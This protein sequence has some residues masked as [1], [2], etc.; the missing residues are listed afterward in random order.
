MK[1]STSSALV[2]LLFTQVLH[3]LS[4]LAQA[5]PGSS[6]PSS[7]SGSGAG[8]T[9]VNL[10]LSSK[11]HNLTATNLGSTGQVAIKVGNQTVQVNAATMLTPAERLAVYQVMSTGQ[12]S[13][14]LGS[15]GNAIGG[16]FNIGA[17]F[18]QYVS[19]L[20]I[21]RGVTA[22]QNAA[23]NSNLSLTGNLTNSGSLLGVS[24]SQDYSSLLISAQNIF[25]RQGALIST[26]L[27]SGGI[28]GLTGAIPSLNLTL[29]A[30]QNIV[31]YG[32]ITSSGN[33]NLSAGNSIINAL[34]TGTSGT[35]PLMQA[36]GN[37]NFN[38]SQIV[39]AGVMSSLN[40]NVNF[41]T[42]GLQ[43]LSINNKNGT[44]Q[45]LL[46]SIN[47]RDALFSGKYDTTLLGGNLL[48]KELN[49]FSGDGIANVRVNDLTGTV[50]V[51]AGCAYVT[52]A[53]DNLS[54]GALNLSG[55]PLFANAAGDLTLTNAMQLVTNGADLALLA[56]GNITASDPV[57]IDTSSSTGSGGD[58]T[59]VAGANFKI[60][61]INNSTKITGASSTGGSINFVTLPGVSLIDSSAKGASGD[62]GNI[63]L[64]AFAG[65]TKGSGTITLPSSTPINANSVGGKAGDVSIIAGGKNAVVLDNTNP[66]TAKASTVQVSISGGVT[67]VGAF[68]SVDFIGPI[69]NIGATG[70]GN[71]SIIGA[72]PKVS[73]GGVTITDG[74]IMSGSF[75]AGTPTASNGRL[76]LGPITS[77][78]NLSVSSGNT[79]VFSG[80]VDVGGNATVSTVANNGNISIEKNF[81][82]GGNISL[83]ANGSGSITTQ[84]FF[85]ANPQV[86]SGAYGTAITP[87]G[88]FA[89]VPNNGSNTV[90]VINTA[91]NKVIANIDLS[92]TGLLAPRGAATSANG[93]FIYV[94]GNSSTAGQGEV[95]VIDTSN[96]TVSTTYTFQNSNGGATNTNYE[97]KYV[98]VSGGLVYV[99][100]D[101]GANTSAATTNSQLTIIDPLN[102]MT[103]T[104]VDLTGALGSGNFG[105]L[106]INPQG[107]RAYIANT[108]SNNITVV[109]LSNYS[110]STISLGTANGSTGPTAIA[111]NP[112]GSRLYA[113]YADTALS[114]GVISIKAIDALSTSSTYN[115][116]ILSQSYTDSKIPQ[117]LT[118][119]PNGAQVIMSDTNLVGI[120]NPIS[121]T[122]TEVPFFPT[123]VTAVSGNGSSNFSTIVNNGGVRNVQT[124]ITTPDSAGKGNVLVLQA[125]TIQT[126]AGKTL[127]LKSTSGVISTSYDVQ[128]GT[129]AANT[130]SSV[131]LSNVGTADSKIGASSA[132]SNGLLFQVNALGGLATTGAITGGAVSLTSV[133]GAITLGGNIGAT[134]TSAITLESSG[135][136]TASSGKLTAKSIDLTSHTG[137]IGTDASHR[138]VT[139]TATMNIY[140]TGA[141]N[142]FVGNTGN[143]L[144]P[145]VGSGT[146]TFDISNA[147]NVTVLNAISGTAVSV[148]TISANGKIS[149]AGVNTPDASAGTSIVLSANGSG[150]IAS[151]APL[152]ALLGSISLTS[153]SGDIGT[154]ALPLSLSTSQLSANTTGAGSVFLTNSTDVKLGNSG[155][156]KTFQLVN[157]GGIGTALNPIGN[158]AG[159]II[160]LTDTKANSSIVFG[161]NI[162][163]ATSTIT[164]DASPSTV[165]VT[166]SKGI[167]TA[168]SLKVTTSTGNINL[169]NVRASKMLFNSTSGDVTVVNNVTSSLL[170]VTGDVVN[171]ANPN[172]ALTIAGDVL[173][174]DITLSSAN[175]TATSPGKIIISGN[176]GNA[177]TDGIHIS[178]TKSGTIT[179]TKS[180]FAITSNSAATGIFLQTEDGAIGSSA[181]PI[182]TVT[183]KLA[184]NTTGVFGSSVFLNNTGANLVLGTSSAQ[185]FTL[186]NTGNIIQNIPDPNNPPTVLYATFVNLTSSTGNIGVDE[187]HRFNIAGTTANVPSAFELTFST[188]G[189]AYFSGNNS[190]GASVQIN[191]AKASFAGGSNGASIWSFGGSLLL[192][193]GATLKSNGTIDFSSSGDIIQLGSVTQ[194]FAPKFII[195]SSTNTGSAKFP[196]LISA[197]PGS[198]VP[199]EISLHSFQDMYIT[200]SSSLNMVNTPLLTYTPPLPDPPVDNNN[201]VLG[202][203]FLTS[204]GAINFANGVYPNGGALVFKANGGNINVGSNVTFTTTSTSLTSSGGSVN[205]GTGALINTTGLV[206]SARDAITQAAAAGV[207]TISAGTISLSA[208][209]AG[210]G[211][212]LN[213]IGFQAGLN[214]VDLTV[215]S[216]GSAFLVAP[217]AGKG[218]ELNF[219]GNSSAVGTFS[220]KSVND[221]RLQ[222]NASKIPIITG[223]TVNI[224]TTGTGKGII[225]NVLGTTSGVGISSPTI[226]LKTA[227]DGIIGDSDA[228]VL[229]SSKGTVTLTATAD[230]NVNIN[231]KNN[232]TLQGALNLNSGTSTGVKMAVTGNL[233]FDT[234]ASITSKVGVDLTAT[235]SITQK[236]TGGT[237][238]ITSDKI[239]L[240]AG[241]TGIG[242]ATN[243]LGV[244]AN[245]TGL[246]AAFSKGNVFLSANNATQTLFNDS[247]GTNFDV[248]SNGSI[249]T[250]S[251]ES[252]VGTSSI[253]LNVT[254]AN[255]G[256]FQLG[257]DASFVSNKITMNVP[258]AATG[259]DGIGTNAQAVGVDTFTTNGTI[260]FSASSKGSINV[261][262]DAA[263]NLGAVSADSDTNPLVTGF[264]LNS[265]GKIGVTDVITAG[266]VF[267]GTS[268]TGATITSSGKGSV[269]GVNTTLQTSNANIGSSTAGLVTGASKLFANTSSSGLINLKST[270]LAGV[271]LGASSSKS[272]FTLAAVGPLTVSGAVSTD[273]PNGS[274]AGNLSLSTTTGKLQVSANV[275]AKEG[276]I[277]IQNTDKNGSIVIDNNLTIDTDVNQAVK[278]TLGAVSIFIGT[279]TSTQNPSP[280]ASIANITVNQVAGTNKAYFGANPSAIS[281]TGAVTVNLVNQSVYFNAPTTAAAGAIQI[282]SGTTITAD[283]LAFVAASPMKTSQN[284]VIPASPQSNQVAPNAVSAGSSSLSANAFVNSVNFSNLPAT[285]TMRI[286]QSIGASAERFAANTAVSS[287]TSQAAPAVVGAA[288]ADSQKSEMSIANSQPL[289]K[290]LSGSINQVDGVFDE[291]QITVNDGGSSKCELNYGGV[292]FAPKK[293]TSVITPFGNVNLAADSIALVV[294]TE[295]G[296]S[297]F[298]LHDEHRGSVNLARDGKRFAVVLGEHLTV[299]K[300]GKDFAELNPVPSIA[301]ADLQTSNGK[302]LNLYQSKFSLT[303]A[304]TGLDSIALL[305]KSADS[306][307][308]KLSDRLYKNA[309]IL[310]Q[311]RVPSTPYARMSA[312]KREENRKVQ[313]V[314]QQP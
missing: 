119:T 48:S 186:K 133:N 117:A 217:T 152:K 219:V 244:D 224:E 195:E 234:G 30:L 201:K 44:I 285:D 135:S 254:G 32:S 166:Q 245:S 54:I 143:L 183:E 250:A 98:A 291:N 206:I 65:T 260:T 140:R 170:G 187:S 276:S 225:Q 110:Q 277:K 56:K 305:K 146:G 179:Q 210:I 52:A 64:I 155:A 215:V 51:T 73:T 221:V 228:L 269:N 279:G 227:T 59:I 40:G 185:S 145:S 263:I 307:K 222:D 168:A 198:S 113:T 36:M 47:L 239:T 248:L 27:P 214:S 154:S 177:L 37:L 28:A 190:N 180:T 194:L 174:S 71:T 300:K 173:G 175:S 240:S 163:S 136:I 104:Y 20:V 255:R 86:G 231:S 189:N 116:V 203:L 265:D 161:G 271:S 162:G 199:V 280:P 96:N 60:P 57:V 43:A 230:K 132:G 114:S 147:G 193:S 111:F 284:I 70:S 94:V 61:D 149:L 79:I 106:A 78:N 16:T 236:S 267:L 182:N 83:T 292:V 200:S 55:D 82:A 66:S 295:C 281:A 84:S 24:T 159:S 124:Y 171:I 85:I 270:N 105:G 153:G 144:L 181:I 109:D 87:Q 118:S 2:F 220:L 129:V 247:K 309:A 21:P 139:S 18:N 268:N 88:T 312:L 196:L 213:P 138:I 67:T 10:D 26:V 126:G 176:I 272:S 167:I 251:G 157:A 12:Q 286:Q 218:E 164:I 50:N 178:T 77:S 212:S 127:T 262:S 298:N 306:S 137:N 115:Q 14:L 34:P 128:G 25:N 22:I 120:Q 289:S 237:T 107:T 19:S 15:L 91:T 216:K 156:G 296:L 223:G 125:P 108:A 233:L 31:N 35:A 45:A 229:A 293:T 197:L 188:A 131:T 252:I 246:V 184:A 287:E 253:T 4:V 95:V 283:P 275:H 99:L 3:P 141:G 273:A 243:R 89:Y 313:F 9:P 297:L 13:I 208:G 46:G 130:T 301:H 249:A 102:P 74:S 142:V 62:A 282:G 226:N 33:L 258:N 264:K 211:T 261:H 90:S 6:S 75:S 266:N 294:V 241:T 80:L 58:I 202:S 278:G 204:N 7:S 207:V 5:R 205:L 41:A 49:V 148:A 232:L 303:S 17:K 53:T 169:N 257:T 256:I 112:T 72:Q 160:N 290:F 259:A 302:E 97:P 314:A 288:R 151:T 242:T 81:K 209:T 274:K 123:G 238:S 42:Q 1:A 121:L 158:I 172:A 38:A 192:E 23:V 92:S 134:T 76:Y 101:Y 235:G 11:N 68:S 311:F 310:M 299:A 29:S 93:Q 39:N 304:I 165:D 100:S 308:R 63:Q 150:S 122:N 8:V 69:H 103:P 191:L